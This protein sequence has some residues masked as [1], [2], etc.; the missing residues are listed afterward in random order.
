MFLAI[1]A[2]SFSYDFSIEVMNGIVS[3]RLSNT[4]GVVTP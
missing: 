3:L 2:N 1:L 4:S